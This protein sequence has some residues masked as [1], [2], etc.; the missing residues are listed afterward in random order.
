[1]MQK[2]RAFEVLRQ[3]S[4]ET[5][6]AYA[7]RLRKHAYGLNKSTEEVIYKFY[8][9]ITASNQ[10]IDYVINLPCNDL[11]KTV[12]YVEQHSR[13]ASSSSSS[14]G[15]DRSHLKCTNCKKT[16]H[17]ARTCRSKGK[18]PAPR[19]KKL[20]AVEEDD[21]ASV[22]EAAE[23]DDAGS[24]IEDPELQCVSEEDLS[25][26]VDIFEAE[27]E[28][29]G[30]RK[31]TNE[32]RESMV[33]KLRETPSNPNTAQGGYRDVP[34]RGAYKSYQVKKDP[35]LKLGK[36]VKDTMS[37]PVAV[38]LNQYVGLTLLAARDK[39]KLVTKLTSDATDAVH[40]FCNAFEIQ[41]VEGSPSGPD[42]VGQTLYVPVLFP[43]CQEA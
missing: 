30:K 6:A 27:I 33:K 18:K 36:E 5:L 29:L 20:D 4:S 12:E 31:G 38:P 23:E 9:S 39:N 11:Q 43:G 25:Q 14:F 26:D 13:G 17:T 28:D 3:K 8:K 22:D 15:A 41:A 1:M 16:G 37:K 32:A 10:V 34:V 19:P 42:S 2:I 24:S 40:A 7:D 21:D 35:K